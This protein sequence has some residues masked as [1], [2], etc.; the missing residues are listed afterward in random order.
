[1]DLGAGGLDLRE[2]RVADEGERG[3]EVGAAV[4]EARAGEGPVNGV[5]VVVELADD[6]FDAVVDEE[7]GGGR[8]GAARQR[9]DD[10][11]GGVAGAVESRLAAAHRAHRVG[12]V[13]ED[14]GGGAAPAGEADE[15]G[16][17][18][19]QRRPRHRQRH[20]RHHQHPQ[21]HQQHV[22]QPHPRG[23]TLHR[24]L[25]ERHRR[26]DRLAVAA[27]IQQVDEERHTRQPHPGD[28][29]GVEE[30]HEGSLQ[31]S[32][33]SSQPG[34]LPRSPT[35]PAASRSAPSS[36]P[37]GGGASVSRSPDPY[38]LSI[39]IRFVRKPV[40]TTSMGWAVLTWM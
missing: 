38:L 1:M 33:V 28:Q 10:L 24:R 5:E 35:V 30:T 14:D 20:Q 8:G 26:P 27:P 22:L 32:A 6:R 18:P 7:D 37:R 19:R 21:R 4:G 3:N 29:R 34:T 17:A 36:R 13:E 12:G 23:V 15:P 31:R 16:P 11:A 2:E 39:A 25:E 40:R 9:P